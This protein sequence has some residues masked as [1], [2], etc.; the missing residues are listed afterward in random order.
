MA[1]E[2]LVLAVPTAAGMAAEDPEVVQEP[3]KDNSA[4]RLD[5]QVSLARS[6]GGRVWGEDAFDC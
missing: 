5:Q 4:Q 6:R 2:L 3:I 1:R